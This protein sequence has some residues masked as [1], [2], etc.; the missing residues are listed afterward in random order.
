M[1]TYYYF[2]DRQGYFKLGYDREGKRVM[3]RTTDKRHA[4]RTSS[5]W[6]VKHMVSKWLVDYYY[7]I[8]EG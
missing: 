2:K 5:E 3:M 4:Y 8:E 1:R 7:W 6:L